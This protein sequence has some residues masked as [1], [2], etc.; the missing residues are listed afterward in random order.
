MK[1]NKIVDE[2]TRE[3]A[4]RVKRISERA[5]TIENRRDDDVTHA[6][7]SDPCS[8]CTFCT[9][10]AYCTSDLSSCL[11]ANQRKRQFYCPRQETTQSSSVRSGCK[12]RQENTDISN[13]ASTAVVECSRNRVVL[14]NE[15]AE[16]SL[17]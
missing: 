10:G 12:R 1:L 11:T 13:R 9:E 6:C 16:L 7:V 5:T 2:R 3:W 17:R 14:G 4:E 8:A 15:A